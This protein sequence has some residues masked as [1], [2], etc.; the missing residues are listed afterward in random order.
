MFLENIAALNHL[1]DKFVIERN[2]EKL[3]IYHSLN[4]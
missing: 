4:L 1:N 3:T 2:F